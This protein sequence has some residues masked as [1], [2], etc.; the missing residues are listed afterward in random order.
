ME[1]LYVVHKNGQYLNPFYKFGPD[2]TEAK[3]FPKE[4]AETIAKD[5]TAQVYPWRAGQATS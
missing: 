5:Y 2:P 4:L 1:E 3:K